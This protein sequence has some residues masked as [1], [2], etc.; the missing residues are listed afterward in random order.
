M[1]VEV[2]FGNRLVWAN[3]VKEFGQEYFYEQAS[4]EVSRT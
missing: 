2:V 3:R 4:I 1:F